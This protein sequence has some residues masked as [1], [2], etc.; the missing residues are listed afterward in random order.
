MELILKI[1]LR[2]LVRQKR[3]NILLGI[4]IAFGMC[5]LVMANAFSHGISEILLNKIIVRI[6]GHIMVTRSEKAGKKERKII[7][8]QERMKQTI[9]ENIQGVREVRE[10]VV[11]TGRALGNGKV[12]QIAL[13]GIEPDDEFLCE[14]DL[15]AGNL[16]DFSYQT[17]VENP[18]VLYDAMAEDLNVRVND[19]VQM[20]LHTIHGQ[21][22]TARLNVVAIIRSGNPFLTTGVFAPMKNLKALKDYAEQEADSLSVVFKQL[23]TPKAVIQEADQLHAAF[24][25]NV[26]GYR[27]SVYSEGASSEVSI[28][29]V[30]P[31]SSARLTFASHLNI[32][33][34]SLDETLDDEK[35]VVLSHPLAETL[36]VNVGDEISCL[37]ETRNAGRSSAKTLRVGAIFQ[38]HG[39]VKDDMVFLHAD[40]VY[41]AYFAA[42]PRDFVDVKNESGLFSFLLK[43]WT[44]LERSSDQEALESKYRELQNEG[45]Q[46][47]VL[48]VQTMYEIASDVLN[49]ETVLDLVTAVAVLVLF[50]IILIGVINTLRMTIRERTREIGTVRAIG[51]Q[52]RDVRLSFVTEVVFLT[53]F[54][55]LAGVVLAGILMIASSLL[56][57]QIESDFTIF[58]VNKH[59]Y[60]VPTLTDIVRNLA[61]L[62]VI[63]F[64]TAYFPA[65]T[66]A[67]MSVADALRHYE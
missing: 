32:V 64:I 24:Q 39:A 16:A 9:L 60:F 31:D 29:A 63:A 40:Q 53:L 61:M 56:T 13:I 21:V 48:D 51:M 38:P 35:A 66:A 12:E 6:T 15:I 8:D 11:A 55:S 22:Q 67:K 27:G 62:V 30:V 20:K 17:N 44:L 52:R 3:R 25:P 43:E 23:D 59:L 2:N 37:H 10:N 47:A 50:G 4:G 1:S 28:F 7:R 36:G 45:W 34:G 18:I 14:V 33:A 19:L 26:A 42:Y 54:A 49:V 58:L 65:G 5:I 57:F 41:D 46:G